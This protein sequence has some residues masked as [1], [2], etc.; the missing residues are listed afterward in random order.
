MSDSK[1]MKLKQLSNAL[2]S[3]KKELPV[4][5][6]R[7]DELEDS[8]KVTRSALFTVAHEIKIGDKIKIKDLKKSYSGILVSTDGS[9]VVL[10]DAKGKEKEVS[11]SRKDVII[12]KVK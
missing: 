6:E 9:T 12:K 5:K 3:F 8:I 2:K 11:L 4:A 7:V 10:K 1:E